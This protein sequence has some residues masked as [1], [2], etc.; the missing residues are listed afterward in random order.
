M[1]DANNELG[2]HPFTSDRLTRI[3]NETSAKIIANLRMM[4]VI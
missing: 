3:Y 2:Q 1:N 4:K